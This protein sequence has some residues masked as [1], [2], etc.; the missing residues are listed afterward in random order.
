MMNEA[1]SR[2]ERPGKR[3]TVDTEV[4]AFDLLVGARCM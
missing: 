2:L 4:F 1:T 3:Y